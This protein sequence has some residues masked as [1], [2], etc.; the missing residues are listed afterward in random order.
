MQRVKFES[1]KVSIVIKK[2]NSRDTTGNDRPSTSLKRVESTGVEFTGS[3]STGS[4]A[5]HLHPKGR[6]FGEDPLHVPQAEA[7]DSNIVNFPAVGAY[8]QEAAHRSSPFTSQK[9]IYFSG[10][11][12]LR[13]FAALLVVITHARDN[14]VTAGLPQPPAWPIFSMGGRAVQFFFVLSG[15]LITFLL[16]HEQERNGSINVKH[17][18][19]RRI[20]RIWPLYFA[21]VTFGCAFYWYIVPVLGVSFGVE[22]PKWLA[23]LLY[24]LFLPNIMSMV[25]HVGGILNVAW[26]IGVEEQYYLMWP[27]LFRRFYRSLP[28]LLGVL[29]VA[30]SALYTICTLELFPG[31]EE[32]GK[33][34]SS[35]QFH[36]MALGGLAAWW[37]Y[38]YPEQV[39]NHWLFRSGAAQFIGFSLIISYFMLFERTNVR[40]ALMIVPLGLLFAWL[41]LTVAWVRN[42]LIRGSLLGRVLERGGE[43]SYGVYFLHMIVVYPTTLLFKSTS[44][45]GL[46]DLV[47]IT[48]Y[49]GVVFG[50]TIIAAFLSYHLFEAPISRL[51]KNF[52]Q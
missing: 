42:G 32:L 27:P 5:A 2:N 19:I 31:P 26:S 28:M 43:I 10:L 25:Y 23:I 6:N 37:L 4:V 39:R 17:F 41:L 29:F 11:N 14:A 13:L 22:Y 16:I 20:L 1:V 7:L 35:L 12:S 48:G 33:V 3:E 34:L 8:K 40:D 30:F 9:H 15:F 51:R 38:W 44:K 24:T 36:Y 52:I 18:Y 46:P 21:V 47:V 49:Y 50:G 45:W